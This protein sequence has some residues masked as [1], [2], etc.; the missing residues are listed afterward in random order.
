MSVWRRTAL[1]GVGN[2][3]DG[4]SVSRSSS[5]SSLGV[6]GGTAV[7]RGSGS[8]RPV[9]PH[10]GS[11]R[12]R[13]SGGV[14]GG[15]GGVHAM[16]TRPESALRGTG[17]WASSDRRRGSERLA[18]A[19]TVD[20]ERGTG[21][22][23]NGDWV[24][25]KRRR[26]P[27][28]S[29][30]TAQRLLRCP[31]S[32]HTAAVLLLL[33]F[34]LLLGDFARDHVWRRARHDYRDRD[35]FREDAPYGPLPFAVVTDMDR[36]SARVEPDGGVGAWV[37]Y[38]RRGELEYR[39]PSPPQTGAANTNTT[40]THAPSGGWWVRWRDQPLGVPLETRIAEAGRGMELSELVQWRGHLLAPCDRTGIVYE[41]RQPLQQRPYAAP[42]YVLA[43]GDGEHVK[44]FKA[45]WMAVQHDALLIG[46]HGRETTSGTDGTHVEN[47]D[48]LWVKRIA[49]AGASASGADAQVSHLNW[50]ERFERL[51]RAAG[52]AF[53][54]YLE[55][56][57]AIWSE[58]RRMWLFLPRRFSQQP[59]HEERNEFRG[60]N[61]YLL[62]DADFQT[63]RVMALDVPLVGER[64][65]SSVKFVPDTADRLAAALRTVEHERQGVYR[66]FMTVFEVD[67]G[68]V[69]MPDMPVG[70][71]KYEGLEFL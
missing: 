8:G 29:S 52:L 61:K 41:I 13:S 38:F 57:A 27:G 19:T 32:R 7:Q 58:R 16:E 68:R 50:T 53:P 44:G 33:L 39:P 42:R 46:G 12:W 18:S 24:G 69:L 45:E 22:G 21:L 37:S 47:D 6:E 26:W 55:H 23:G 15:G 14:G 59:Y 62:T 67:T 17:E 10:R 31:S 20:V 9:L 5:S 64:G 49:A 34:V 51:R 11:A 1:G 43:T 4:V 2:E 60:W 40:M 28:R 35:R 54:G 3:S 63:V 65:F 71:A 36:L 48:P 70:E 56:E 25:E 66:T 30:M